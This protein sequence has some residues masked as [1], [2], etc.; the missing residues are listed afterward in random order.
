MALLPEEISRYARHLC[1]PEVGIDGQERLRAGSV[2]VIGLGGLGSPA[3]LYLAAAGVGRIGLAV[4]IHNLQRQIIH[5]EASV[6]RAKLESAAARLRA[7]NAHVELDLHHEA[8]S[9]DNAHELFSQYDL[10]LDGTDNFPTR[11]LNNDA[12]FLAG[13]PLV[14]GSI[15]QFE[16]QV[17]VFDPAKGGPC[18]R[19]LFPR[20]PAP[21]EVP[22]CDEA[23]V[24]GA[25]CGM[26]GSA[27]AL[28]ALKLLMGIGDP[29]RGR[30][31]V[32]DTL[33][34]RQTS[35]RVK[36]DPDC[37]LCG[38]APVITGL[39]AENYVFTCNREK[40][41]EKMGDEAMEIDADAAKAFL[42]SNPGTVL[43][44]VREPFEAEI[45]RLDGAHL[46]P[47]KQLP[48]RFAELPRVQPLLVYCHHGM[49][50]LRATE[51]LRTR[52]FESAKSMKGGIDA[53]ARIH[54]PAM[55]RY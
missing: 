55:A 29:L 33:A 8:V 10:I 49:R 14:Y 13:K 31:L 15:F 39:T 16:G 3:A 42:E 51:F 17:S 4:E 34:Q 7:L 32:L 53:W 5:T 1:L 22:N 24:F 18:Y 11:Y 38:D 23:G 48:E 27:Q 2:L 6:G 37:P 30:L 43:L 35:I 54:D 40:Q 44:D 26:V 52:G 21:G 45:C 20:M 36:P 25:L 28:E 9:V 46:I 47:L 19:C 12:A 41:D 50:S